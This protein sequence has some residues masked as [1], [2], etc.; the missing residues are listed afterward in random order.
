MTEIKIKIDDGPY[1]VPIRKDDTLFFGAIF[2]YRI[3]EVD[4]EII[5]HCGSEGMHSI[6]QL[7]DEFKRIIGH[8]KRQILLKRSVRL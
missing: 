3:P 7:E 5:T 4:D 1:L 2:E 6:K 8:L